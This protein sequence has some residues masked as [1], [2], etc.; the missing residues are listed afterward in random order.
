MGMLSSHKLWE[1]ALLFLPFF[2]YLLFEGIG[3]GFKQFSRNKPALF[4]ASIFLMHILGLIMTTDFDYAV[5]DLR[6]KVPLFLVP[7]II[8]TSEAIGKK[9]FYHFM[10]FFVL[11]V[12]ARSGFNAWLLQTNQFIDIRDVAHNVSHIIFSLLLT[13]CIYSLFYFSLKRKTAATVF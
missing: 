5:K 8:S 10:L 1:K 6:T 11:T 9:G 7:L 2:V 3:H 4:F 13:L 12:L